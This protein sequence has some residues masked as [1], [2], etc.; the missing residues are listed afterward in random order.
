MR[1]EVESLRRRCDAERRRIQRESPTDQQ[2]LDALVEAEEHVKAAEA[3][4]DEGSVSDAW[5][6]VHRADEAFVE[7]MDRT[8]LDLTAANTLRRVRGFSESKTKMLD[9][10]IG[11][12]P[13]K[14]LPLDELRKRVRHAVEVRNQHWDVYFQGGELAQRQLTAYGWVT[15]GL[16]AAFWFVVQVES[17]ALALERFWAL[18]VLLGALAGTLSAILSVVSDGAQRILPQKVRE[19]PWQYLR[20]LFGGASAVLTVA[21]LRTP[22][23][24]FDLDESGLLAW[25]AVAG[26]SESVWVRIAGKMAQQKD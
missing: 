18:V 23:L 25:A 15:A 3:A 19:A 2:A 9:G 26:F 16:V 4:K 17:P 24:G 5:H 22:L 7:C 6:H 1:R 12:G 11:K 21:V 10:T 14:G 20:P 13:R 8:L